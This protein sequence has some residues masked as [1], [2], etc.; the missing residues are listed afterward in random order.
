MAVFCCLSSTQN[1]STFDLQQ[2]GLVL[3][4]CLLGVLGDEVDKDSPVAGGGELLFPWP[5][6]RDFLQRLGDLLLLLLLMMMMMMLLLLGL[7]ADS[8]LGGSGGRS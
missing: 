5:L 6:G 1:F 3:L 2:V 8:F 4:S 7:Q